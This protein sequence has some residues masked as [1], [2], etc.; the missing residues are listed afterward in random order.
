[1]TPMPDPLRIEAARLALQWSRL[2]CREAVGLEPDCGWYHGFW[3]IAR[4]L[5]VGR[6]T[7]GQADFLSEVLRAHARDPAFRRVLVSGTADHAL[8]ALVYRAYEE[9]GADVAL[10]VL[11]RCETPLALCRWHAQRTGRRVHTVCADILDRDW[12]GSFDLVLANSFLGYFHSEQRPA[13]FRRWAELLRPGGKAVITNR[14]RTASDGELVTFGADEAQRFCAQIDARIGAR[15]QTLGIDAAVV[16]GAAREYVR[17]F[18]VHPVRSHAELHDEL[19]LAG[20]SDV[21]ADVVASH[22][23]ATPVS[24]P[25]TQEQ[26]SYARIVAT[27][28]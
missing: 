17:R 22:R 28:G 13:L 19:R 20:F 18:A 24:G 15:A 16:A 10:T 4:L 26:G 9:A 14:V 25:S 5:D 2:H 12:S 8:P 7:G 11:D 21:R 3:Q 6:V 1:M 23:A 27:R